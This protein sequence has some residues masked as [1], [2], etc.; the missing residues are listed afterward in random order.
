MQFGQGLIEQAGA[1][2]F[3]AA[4]EAV[5]PGTKVTRSMSTYASEEAGLG[6]NDPGCNQQ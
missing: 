1:E 4:I 3:K 2:D 5:S 6:A